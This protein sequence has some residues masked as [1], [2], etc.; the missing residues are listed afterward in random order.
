M[1][2]TARLPRRLLFGISVTPTAEGYHDVAAQAEAADRGGLDLIGIQDHPYQR[3]FLDT[4]SLIA[5]LLARTEHISI[6]PDVANLALRHPTML[7]KAAVTL[8]VMSAGR[9]ELGVG[10]GGFADAVAGMGGQRRSA[11]EGM[12]ALEEAVPLLRA[13]FDGQR[14]VRGAGA[15]YPVPGYPPGPLPAHPIEIWLGVYK[16]RGLRLVGRAGDGW[17][18]SLRFLPPER[19][20]DAAARIDDAALE[21]GRDPRAIRRIYNVWGSITDGERGDGLLEGPVDQW[22][23]TLAAWHTGLGMDAV[24]YWPPDLSSGS[25]ERFAAEVVPAVREAISG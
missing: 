21:S 16:P 25:V 19:F 23:E 12:E 5:D 4:F 8:D 7:A 15:H 17:V 11:R 9:F 1:T 14:V 2:D 6:F 22:V 3:R 18:P 10:A 24:V 20:L 13:V